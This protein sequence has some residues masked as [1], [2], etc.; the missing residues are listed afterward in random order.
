MKIRFRQTSVPDVRE[1]E[2]GEDAS[3]SEL[4]AE[5]QKISS[6]EAEN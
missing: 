5:L 1:V 3:V 4:K 2:I 6:I